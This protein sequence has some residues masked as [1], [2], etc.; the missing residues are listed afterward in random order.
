MC[1]VHGAIAHELFETGIAAEGLVAVFLGFVGGLGGLGSLGGAAGVAFQVA[2]GG[3]FLVG[4]LPGSVRIGVAVDVGTVHGHVG[5]ECHG[6]G[7]VPVGPVL[8][9][10]IHDVLGAVGRV[11]HLHVENDAGF[12]MDNLVVDVARVDDRIF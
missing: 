3:M 7:R 2:I 4:K 10:V 12:G 6:V 8:S 5:V 1:L 9:V 11:G